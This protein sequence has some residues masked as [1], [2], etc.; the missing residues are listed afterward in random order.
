M[1]RF[2]ARPP[3]CYTSKAGSSYKSV[4]RK[5]NLSQA[6]RSFCWQPLLHLDALCRTNVW[7][8]ASYSLLAAELFL[9][10]I[11]F[12]FSR[13]HKLY[14]LV[15]SVPNCTICIQWSQLV[16]IT[17]LSCILVDCLALSSMYTVCSNYS[18]HPTLRPF[19]SPSSSYPHQCILPISIPTSFFLK[20][21]MFSLTKWSLFN[22][23]KLIEKDRK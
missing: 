15:P 21:L 2:I 20:F 13:Y 8:T 12:M 18:L 17:N 6:T 16:V 14:S 10:C 1:S 7:C 3:P 22:S 19:L 5:S 9:L 11:L 23:Y 4:R